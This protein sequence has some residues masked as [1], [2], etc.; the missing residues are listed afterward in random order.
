MAAKKAADTAVK[1]EEVKAPVVEKKE[2]APKAEKKAAAPKKEAAPKA[3]KKAAAP[4]K[5]AAPKAEKKEAAPK[6]EKKAA[7]KAA[8]KK[9]AAPKK[10]AKASESVVIE[11]QGGQI[12]VDDIVAAVKAVAKN[13]KEIKVYYQPE[14]GIAYYTADGVEGSVNL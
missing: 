9:A 7:P 12:A 6:A 4:K 2:A 14:N 10:A 8:A 1:A 11:F 3:E 13:A 5:E